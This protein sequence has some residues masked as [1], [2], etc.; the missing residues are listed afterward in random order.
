MKNPLSVLLERATDQLRDLQQ[1]V[2]GD[3]VVQQ[4]AHADRP[5][6][7]VRPGAVQGNQRRHVAR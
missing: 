5:F 6:R 7:R 3:G 2:A 4:A 1:F